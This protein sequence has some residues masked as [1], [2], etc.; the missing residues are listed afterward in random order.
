VAGELNVAD[1]DVDE[2]HEPQRVGERP[3]A[4][5]ELETVGRGNR[6]GH[7]G[8]DR[9]VV[10]DHA[11]ADWAAHPPLRV[12]SVPWPR[13]AQMRTCPPPAG[14]PHPARKT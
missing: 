4:A 9:W 12:A 2:R 7:S 5:R 8:D 1:N 3:A 13:T 11:D 14:W 10:V 6:V